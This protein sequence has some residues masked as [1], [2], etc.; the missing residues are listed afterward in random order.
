[1]SDP[2]EQRLREQIAR[3]FDDRAARSRQSAAR[4]SPESV[5]HAVYT[6]NAMVWRHAARM[7]RSRSDVAEERS[8][9]EK[10]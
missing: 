7:V 8:R 1:M 10:S 6:S 2:S 9:K 5:D 3:M 4:T